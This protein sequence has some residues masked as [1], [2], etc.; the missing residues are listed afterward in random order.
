[1]HVFAAG[2][3]EQF[4]LFRQQVV[5]F[6]AQFHF[7]QPAQ[8][9]QAHVQD[10]LG[11]HVGQ[12]GAAAPVLGD[13]GGFRLVLG[14]D[15]LDHPVEVEEGDDIALQHLQPVRDLVQPMRGA[16][17][18]HGAAVVQEG[19]QHLAQAA[20]LGRAPVDQ[21]VHVQR[22]ADFE[23]RVL[24]QRLH[25]QRGLDGARLGFQH[26]PDILGRFVAHIA[27]DRDFLLVYEVRDPLD[28]L[29]FLHLVGDLGHDDLVLPAAQI[30]FVPLRAQAEAALAGLVGIEDVL[31]AFHQHAARREVGAGDH[32]DQRFG[33]R[34]RVADQVLER[35]AQLA[36]IVR[37]DRGR[38]AHGNPRRP[39]GQQVGEGGGQDL[40][41]VFAPVIG[42]LEVDG[43]LVQPF[44]HGQCDRRQT[45]FGVARRGGIVAVDVPKIPLPVHHGITHREVLREPHHRV[46]DRRVPVR[47]KI[48]HGVAGNLRAF[49]MLGVRRKV[50]V[51]HGKQNA[52]VHRL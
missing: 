45:C 18:Q 28:Q 34:V 15:D 51:A 16:A 9:A 44:H 10:R 30:F 24:E 31:A 6:A 3:F 20:D 26:Q 5:A 1:M 46:V 47:V 7:L 19:P 52:P 4:R 49:A 50:Q 11:L 42:R 12:E 40:G 38:H 35:L 43:V 39:V 37:R 2:Q 27:E 13:Q 14:A 22:N 23:V 48:P 25:Q 17:Q 41:F 33:P 36:H 21:H 29:G 32:L 8:A